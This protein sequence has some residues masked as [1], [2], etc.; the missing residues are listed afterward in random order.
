MENEERIRRLVTAGCWTRVLLAALA[1]AASIAVSAAAA[2]AE[3]CGNHGSGYCMDDWND[4]GY[5]NPVKMY[6]GGGNNE[7]FGA[8]QV[9]PCHSH[10]RVTWSCPF[11]K[12]R[13]DRTYHNDPVV[14]IA[15]SS[16]L[17]LGTAS[18][19][20]GEL[21][22]CGY[23]QYGD[24]AGGGT[25]MVNDLHGALIDRYWTNKTGTLRRVCSSGYLGGAVFTSYL[26]TNAGCEWGGDGL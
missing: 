18:T 16:G 5:T 7:Y 23:D 10:Y 1:L 22:P 26:G 24:G 12:K 14:E 21:Q 15:Y 6:Y 13:W 20:D 8:I 11:T 17:C 19:G 4:G 25:I 9:D 2:S 3:M